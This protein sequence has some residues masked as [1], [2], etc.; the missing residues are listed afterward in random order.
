MSIYNL[1]TSDDSFIITK[2]TSDLDVE[3]SYTVTL[4]ECECPAGRRPTCRHRQMLPTMLAQGIE[5]TGGFYD[6]DN[7]QFLEP[8]VMDQG[9]SDD[10]DGIPDTLEGDDKLDVTETSSEPALHH[11]LTTEQLLNLP[12]YEGVPYREAELDTPASFDE[13]IEQRMDEARESLDE[14]NKLHGLRYN[15]G[16]AKLG[17]APHPLII[18]TLKRRI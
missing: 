11:V 3:S 8:E 18:G 9:L 17:T 1:R 7:D 5:D 4:S 13:A 16:E 12:Q 6:F 2:F 10:V 15:A 14:K